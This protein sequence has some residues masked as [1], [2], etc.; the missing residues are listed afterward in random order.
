MDNRSL[1]VLAAS[2]IACLSLACGVTERTQQAGNSEALAPAAPEFAWPDESL[3]AVVRIAG[4]GE[5]RIALYPELAPDTVD[6]FV[7]LADEDFYVGTTFHR[8]V[9][10]FMIQGGS[11]ASRDMDP[12]ND[13]HGG[14]GYEI[15]DEF[16]DAPHLR[17]AVSMANLGRENSGGSQFFITHADRPDLDGHYTLFG[18]VVSGMEV[19][20][21][22]TEVEI[23]RAG[24]WGSE[25]RPIE[26]VVIEEVRIEGAAHAQS[27]APD[28]G[29]A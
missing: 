6:N 23:D 17:G 20:D 28:D 15:A 4:M 1:A 10:G 22:I 8:V 14:P 11:S 3:V 25:N 5:V 24:R 7:K 2:V 16:H 12:Y 9:P 21:A 18:R 29:D 19:I 27:G 13:A 26:N